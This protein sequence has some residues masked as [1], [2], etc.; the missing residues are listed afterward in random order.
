MRKGSGQAWRRG[1]IETCQEARHER[2]VGSPSLPPSLPAR[3]TINHTSTLHPSNPYFS[4]LFLS[5]NSLSVCPTRPY[6]VACLANNPMPPW[7][8][9]PLRVL[10]LPLP[11]T[12]WL[13]SSSPG[14]VLLCASCKVCV[15]LQLVAEA[16]V[17][18]RDQNSNPPSLPPLL[19]YNLAP[20]RRRL[21]LRL[22]SPGPL[23]LPLRWLLL[24]QLCV[25]LRGVHLALGL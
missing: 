10:P 14:Y 20:G 5:N 24:L 17:C 2:I 11:V 13:S 19:T 4:S 7:A 18:S 9:P 16:K 3:H 22:Q 1:H 25:H 21:P 6:Q 12:P 15:C 23:L 8:P